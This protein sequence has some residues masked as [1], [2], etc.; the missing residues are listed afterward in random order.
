[1]ANLADFS[2]LAGSCQGI[3]FISRPKDTCAAETGVN[4][5]NRRRGEYF[6]RSGS[7]SIESQGTLVWRLTTSVCPIRFLSCRLHRCSLLMRR[8]TGRSKSPVV[9]W[10][11][12][13]AGW[14]SLFPA[15]YP[16]VRL[17]TC[18]QDST[19]RVCRWDC[20]LSANATEISR[21]CK[22]PTLT[23]RRV[24]GTWTGIRQFFLR[25]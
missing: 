3:A 11:R 8:S 18:L 21:P 12:I 24:A 13:I 15:H 10:I 4:L 14:K 6:R 9:V 25:Y 2:A 19:A 20:K 7:S 17:L 16:V 23:N 22:W 5:G 1:M